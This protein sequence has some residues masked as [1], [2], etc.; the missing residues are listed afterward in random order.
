MAGKTF[1]PFPAHAQPTI[2]QFYVSCKRP[3]KNI[4]LQSKWSMILINSISAL[5]KPAGLISQSLHSD[6]M[7]MS[8]D[9]ASF[10]KS[11]PVYS[12]VKSPIRLGNLSL[13]TL[14]LQVAVSIPHNIREIFHY[15][16]I[17]HERK[18]VHCIS[19]WPNL[20]SLLWGSMQYTK[21]ISLAIIQTDINSCL[22]EIF[23]KSG[24]HT[25]TH[26]DV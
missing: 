10:A 23:R 7:S 17:F 2:L 3:I 16:K 8:G 22:L 14:P 6:Q 18:A 9:M 11:G 25:Y 24:T 19:T 20:I 1:P 5:H 15:N 26:T 13:P 4:D 21:W 12:S